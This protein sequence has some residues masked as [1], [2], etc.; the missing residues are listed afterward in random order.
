MRQRLLNQVLD[1]T[2]IGD[3]TRACNG[4][5]IVGVRTAVETLAASPAP[6]QPLAVGR[7]AAV[8]PDDGVRE[9]PPALP[10]PEEGR[11]P[12][13]ADPDR[14]D[15]APAHA[16]LGEHPKCGPDLGLPEKLGI[17]L[18]PVGLRID[19]R[20]LWMLPGIFLGACSSRARVSTTAR[21]PLAGGD[22]A[23][24][25]P[26]LGIPDCDSPGGRLVNHMLRH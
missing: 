11:L 26:A 17:M 3:S 4:P 21:Y 18:D 10:L 16:G 15:L 7:G 14:G 23:P 1:S 9:R 13:V 19:Y 24:L 20:P 12:L 2:R 8:L 5:C 25:W 6:P 22:Q